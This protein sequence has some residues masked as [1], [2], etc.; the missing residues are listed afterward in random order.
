MEGVG[1]LEL[2]VFTLPTCSTCSVA[3]RIAFEVAEKFGLTCREVNMNTEEGLKEGATYQIR[4][5][6]SI[7]LNNEVI[8]RGHLIS[9]ERLEEEVQKRLEK[10][11][12]RVS[13]RG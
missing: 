13:Q 6:P 8:V 1:A 12:A 5:A 9:K 4:S 11:R 7:V 10:W 2:K 3:K